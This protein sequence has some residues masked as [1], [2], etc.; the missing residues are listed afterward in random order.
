MQLHIIYT[1]SRM[2]LSKA[3]YGSWREVQDAFD[4]YQSSLGPWSDDE[5]IAY[6]ANEHPDMQPSPGDQVAALLSCPEWVRE[7]TFNGVVPGR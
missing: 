3:P 6:L 5:V 1:Q 4:D 2:L 7:V